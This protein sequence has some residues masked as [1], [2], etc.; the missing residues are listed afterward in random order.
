MSLPPKR[1]AAAR[2][3]LKQVARGGGGFGGGGGGFGAA[4]SGGLFGTTNTTSSSSGGLFGA[5]AGTAAFGTG[6]QNKTAFS[7][8]WLTVFHDRFVNFICYKKPVEK[9]CAVQKMDKLFC[10]CH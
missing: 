2:L 5:S 3:V 1:V 8:Y 4:S 6:T 7:E 10:G 9:C